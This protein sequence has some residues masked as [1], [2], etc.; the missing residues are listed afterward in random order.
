[1]SQPP[2]RWVCRILDLP[3]F[4]ARFAQAVKRSPLGSLAFVAAMEARSCTDFVEGAL[5]MARSCEGSIVEAFQGNELMLEQFWILAT[6][7]EKA[8][9][10]STAVQLGRPLQAVHRS[11]P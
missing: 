4:D 6:S 2:D 3:V 5:R 7:V 1:M 9:F 11:T 8:Y 10:E